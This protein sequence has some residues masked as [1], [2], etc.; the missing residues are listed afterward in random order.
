MVRGLGVRDEG[1]LR[2]TALL[3]VSL[4]LIEVT[5]SSAG[6]GVAL[7]ALRGVRVLRVVV[8]RLVGGLLGWAWASASASWQAISQWRKCWPSGQPSNCQI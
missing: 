3:G 7:A 4:G 6:C 5:V 2:G 1:G 8:L